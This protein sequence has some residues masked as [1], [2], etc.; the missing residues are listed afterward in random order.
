MA[1]TVV[2]AGLDSTSWAGITRKTDT[3]APNTATLIVAVIQAGG[4]L[5]A[6][7]GEAIV[8]YALA[9]HARASVIAVVWAGR[10]GAGGTTPSLLTDTAAFAKVELAMLAA[11]SLDVSLAIPCLRRCTA[12]PARALVSE[13]RHLRLQ[14]LEAL[15]QP[16]HG[17]C[18][19]AAAGLWRDVD[20]VGE[21]HLLLALQ[22]VLVQ[23]L[24]R[25]LASRLLQ[26]GG[27]HGYVSGARLAAWHPDIVHVAEERGVGPSCP[28]QAKALGEQAGASG[29][30]LQ[31]RHEEGNGE[32]GAR[33]HSRC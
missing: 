11:E 8:T 17:V 29:T 25:R 22:G 7:P 33:H 27:G 13:G 4:Q 5:T 14:R 3:L 31:G 30:K 26:C 21:N 28:S 12:G 32:R 2:W 6:L 16:L 15:Q 23:L 9:V 24:L 19:G 18:V 10:F 1:S 20:A